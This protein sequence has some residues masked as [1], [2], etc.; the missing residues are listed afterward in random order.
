[1]VEVDK[2]GY[3]PGVAAQIVKNWLALSELYLSATPSFPGQLTIANWEA[4]S[5]ACLAR[6]HYAQQSVFAFHDRR[7]DAAVVA[8]VAFE[9][10]V[11]FAWLLV[12]PKEHHAR[13]LR[14]EHDHVRDFL[15]DVGQRSGQHFS[16]RDQH[17]ALLSAAAAADRLPRFVKCAEDAD[18]HWGKAMPDRAWHFRGAYANLYRPYSAFVHPLLSGIH[19]FIVSG[20]DR[21]EIAAE[22]D[23]ETEPG[24]VLTAST[25]LLAD[26]LLVC[27]HTFGWPDKDAIRRTATRGLAVENGQ[28]VASE[29]ES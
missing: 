24:H 8:R 15:Q 18:D 2:E 22:P 6:G 1:M 10:L 5:L 27:A 14:S 13:F 25:R 29:A 23:R 21:T 12:S 4:I 3:A 28:L 26:A 19:P 20:A 17:L 7:L 16:G 9:H 11:V